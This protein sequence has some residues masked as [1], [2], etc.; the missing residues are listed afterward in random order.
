MVWAGIILDG[1]T[2]LSVF[3]KDSMTSVRCRDNILLAYAKLFRDAVG[4]N[5]ILMDYNAVP[6]KCQL[7][8]ENF[9]LLDWP[10]RSPDINQI[11]TAWDILWRKAG[12]RVSPPKNQSRPENN[13]SCELKLKTIGTYK[14]PDFA[15]R[16]A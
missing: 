8:D 9:C 4:L 16:V 14:L 5:F 15:V 1:W 7:A 6:D 12:T 3:G 13:V 11:E 10:A 2:L